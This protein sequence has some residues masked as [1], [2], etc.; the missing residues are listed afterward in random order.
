MQGKN[1]Y[2]LKKH[3]IDYR[4]QSYSIKTDGLVS[5]FVPHNHQTFIILSNI[6]DECASFIS[7]D[8]VRATKNVN[9]LNTSLFVAVF[10]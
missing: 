2:K 7:F 3:K 5:H 6:H 9:H 8:H 1:E 10:V 4:Y